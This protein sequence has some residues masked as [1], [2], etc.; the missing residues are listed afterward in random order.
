MVCPDCSKSYSP[1]RREVQALGLDVTTMG[2]LRF[3]R[4]EGCESCYHQGLKGRFGL[5]EIFEID[6][7]I[8]R[9]IYS[10]GTTA[11]LRS[12]AKELGMRSMRDDGVR[13]V[14]AGKTTVEEVLS[15]TA[16]DPI[17]RMG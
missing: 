7:E 17:A 4:G 5:F 6:E 16:A 14:V 10:G 9:M 13:K 15:A 8:E 11:Q 2:R 3:A 12:V 1:T